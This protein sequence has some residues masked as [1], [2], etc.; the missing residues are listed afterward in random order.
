MLKLINHFVVLLFLCD[1]VGQL[2]GFHNEVICNETS[3]KL[4][5]VL[6]S[7]VISFDLNLIMIGV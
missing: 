4:K 5:L 1:E 6:I 2:V 3:L 7:V